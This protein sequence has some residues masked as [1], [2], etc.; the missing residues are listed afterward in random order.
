VAPYDTVSFA[1][2]E[3]TGTRVA[4][5]VARLAALD[6]MEGARWWNRRRR[7]AMS[8]ALIACAEELE[9]DADAHATRDVDP[10]STARILAMGGLGR[11]SR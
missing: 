1:A 7:G 2:G 5:C 4:S 9:R 10:V 3:S 6:L 8:S 11:P